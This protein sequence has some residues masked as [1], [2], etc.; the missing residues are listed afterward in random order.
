MPNE[1]C[2]CLREQLSRCPNTKLGFII[3]RL[4][5][6]ND[7]EWARFMSH[8]KSRTYKKLEKSG[9][10]GLIPYIWDTHEDVAMA[11]VPEEQVRT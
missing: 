6:A 7:D 1:N 8:F 4:T 9:D 3:Y 10:G 11:D 5:Y 2:V